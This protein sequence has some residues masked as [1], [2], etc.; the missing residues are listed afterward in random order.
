MATQMREYILNVASE[1][2]SSQGINAT[3]VDTI[4]AKADIAKV[5][6]YKYFKSKEQLILEYLR[7]Y[8]GK[9]WKK[10]SEVTEKEA[11]ATA[12][13]N[14][15]VNA[16]LDWI[17][18]PEFKGFAFIN[19]SVEFPQ[20]EN[21]V[22]Q[23]SLEF[24]QTLRNTLAELAR[25]AGIKNADTLALQLALVVEGTAIT[26][27]TQRGTGAVAHAKELAKILI[28]SAT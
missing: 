4:V 21:P 28:R 26:E 14:A 1:L 11:D 25:E 17:G 9:L 20:S 2:F 22:H 5:T 23:T 19:A 8:D 3:S 10:L 16:M 6:L 15:L 12:K 18:D 7:E 13:L 24:A 27:R